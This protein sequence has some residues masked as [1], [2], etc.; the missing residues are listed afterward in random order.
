MTFGM[1][2]AYDPLFVALEVSF[3]EFRLLASPVREPKEEVSAK[4]M[5][6]AS[7]AGWDQSPTNRFEMLERKRRPEGRLSGR[8]WVSSTI[9]GY[10]LSDLEDV[11]I[12]R[13]GR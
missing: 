6:Y 5:F 1:R 11:S 2:F 7:E 13:L 4:G 9:S 12:P 3:R 10:Q 8:K